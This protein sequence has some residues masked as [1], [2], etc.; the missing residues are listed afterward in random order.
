MI[1]NSNS[2]AGQHRSNSRTQAVRSQTGS[3]QQE[4]TPV[5]F[6]QL[7]DLILD[8]KEHMARLEDRL[9]EKVGETP[10]VFSVI[11]AAKLLRRKPFTVREWCRQG[12]IRCHRAESGRGPYT[13]WRIPMESIRAYQANGL[14]PSRGT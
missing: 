9:P 13:E 11:E 10:Q 2:S 5:G 8:L 7:H 4:M 6:Q 1:A 12:R 14:L 3:I